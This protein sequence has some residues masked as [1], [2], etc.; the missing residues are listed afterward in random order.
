MLWAAGDIHLIEP[1]S[2]ADLMYPASLASHA[3]MLS[4][5]FQHLSDE[6]VQRRT[7]PR[8]PVTVDLLDQRSSAGETLVMLLTKT[9]VR[10]M[11]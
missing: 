1:G 9:V 3:S 8:K 10:A 6:V 7:W 2:M 4:G 11:F 5:F